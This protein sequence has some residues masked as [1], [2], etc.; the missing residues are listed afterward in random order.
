MSTIKVALQYDPQTVDARRDAKVEASFD[1]PSQTWTLD[2]K[3]AEKWADRIAT[4]VSASLFKSGGRLRAGARPGLWAETVANMMAL[5]DAS[6]ATL[7]GDAKDIMGLKAFQPKSEPVTETTSAATATVACPPSTAAT[8]SV[9]CCLC[10][11]PTIPGRK[12]CDECYR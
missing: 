12:Y 11:D 10:G 3:A 1:R 7:S 4:V 9:K 8:Y 5:Y 6:E 2:A